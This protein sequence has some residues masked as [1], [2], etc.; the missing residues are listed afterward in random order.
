[1]RAMMAWLRAGVGNGNLYKSS[2]EHLATAAKNGTAVVRS[3]T[4]QVLPL[5]C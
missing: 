1:M 5:G 3:S 2:I 4:S